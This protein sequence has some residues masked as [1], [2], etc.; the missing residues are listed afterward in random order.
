MFFNQF[1]FWNKK[2]K[3]NGMKTKGLFT[4]FELYLEMSGA[5]EHKDGMD[6]VCCVDW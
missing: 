1:D 6:I 5:G 4:V 2:K 3:A